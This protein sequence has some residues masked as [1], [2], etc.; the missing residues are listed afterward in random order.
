MYGSQ[1]DLKALAHPQRPRQAQPWGIQQVHIYIHKKKLTWRIIIYCFSKINRFKMVPRW[2]WCSRTPSR[3]ST[4]STLLSSASTSYVHDACY[5]L[6]TNRFKTV[7]ALYRVIKML[8]ETP[9]ATSSSSTMGSTAS[10]RYVHQKWLRL[11]RS[12]R[13]PERFLIP[14]EPLKINFSLN[15]RISKCAMSI[16]G[17]H[18][19]YLLYLM[20]LLRVSESILITLY[21]AETV[22]NRFVFEK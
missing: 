15:Y 3:T 6:K 2:S 10:I 19:W 20:R 5:F 13:V 18:N 16:F 14:Q 7:P 11:T 17:E 4:S 22:F 12:L 1:G 8:S 21:L 9:S